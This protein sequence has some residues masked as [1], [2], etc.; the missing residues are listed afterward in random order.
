MVEWNY[1]TGDTLDILGYRLY[2]DTGHNNELRMIFDGTNIPQVKKFLF[3]ESVNLGMM[4]DPQLFYRFQV[5][6]VNFN[7]EGTKS[8]I[9]LL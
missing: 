1:I 7:G 4:V 8:D 5:S 2:G 3:D 6:A 9:A